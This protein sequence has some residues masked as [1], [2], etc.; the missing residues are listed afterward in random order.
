MTWQAKTIVRILLL[1][2]TILADDEALKK[3]LKTLATHIS[4]AS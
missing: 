4:V 1:I 2:A 3:E